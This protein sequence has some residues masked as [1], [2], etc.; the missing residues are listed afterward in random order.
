MSEVRWKDA[1]EEHDYPGAAAYL[2]LGAPGDQVEAIVAA[3]RSAPSTHHKAKDLLRAAGLPALPRDNPHVAGD[4]DKIAHGK[5]LSPVLLVRGEID[6]GY[7]LVVADGYHRICASWL[8][9]ENTDIPCR[10][11]PRRPDR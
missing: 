8:S 10:L 1:P 11:V 3:L 4:L 5:A 9:D 2:A 6:H 7:A